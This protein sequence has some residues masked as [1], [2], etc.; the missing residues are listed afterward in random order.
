MPVTDAGSPSL[1]IVIPAYNEEDT[2]YPCVVAAINQTVAAD[3]IFIIDNRSTD[4]T[5]DIL[6][7]LIIQYPNAP[8]RVMRQDELQGLVP[9]RNVGFNAVTSD[10]I[11]RI[12]SDAVLEPNWVENVKNLFSDPRVDASTG[13]VIYYDMPMRRYMALADDTAR[14]AMYRLATSYKFLFGTNMALRRSVW[15]AIRDEVC[16]DADIDMH[17]DIDL[18]VHIHD[19]GFTTVYCSTMVAGMSARR[20][21]DTPRDFYDYVGRFDRTYRRHGIRKRRLRAPAWV[22]LAIYPIAKGIRWGQ[23]LTTHQGKLPPNTAS[24]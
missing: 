15:E 17:E 22:F 23:K 21:D 7:D 8:I 18:S 16:L 2:I 4:K 13:P 9:T 12:D 24:R 19:A 6:A 10:I 11:G 14:K 5:P 20:V 1:A 3:E